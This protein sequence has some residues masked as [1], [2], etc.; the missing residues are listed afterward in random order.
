MRDE[1]EQEEIDIDVFC[2]NNLCAKTSTCV[3][4]E[5]EFLANSN[6]TLTKN[7]SCECPIGFAGEF[8]ERDIRP[9]SNFVC[10]NNAT[11]DESKVNP[12]EFKCIC[13]TGYEGT[14][15]EKNVFCKNVVCFNNGNCFAGTRNYSCLCSSFFVGRHCETKLSRLVVLEK[16]SR[17]ISI[18]GIV[19]IGA[20]VVFVIAMDFMRFAFHIEPPSLD[21]QRKE[22]KRKKILEKVKHSLRELTHKYIRLHVQSL[23]SEMQKPAPVKKKV[24]SHFSIMNLRFIDDTSDEEDD[25]DHHPLMNVS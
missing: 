12:L 3:P 21:T 13:Q 8:C 25:F 15:C 19:F 6:G 14:F 24:K 11:C 23:L 9:C 2:E 22:R 5:L 10:M 16:V 1:S 7:Y 20:C 4:Y 17:S 18:S